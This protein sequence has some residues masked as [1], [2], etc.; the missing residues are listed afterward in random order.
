MYTL[1]TLLFL[2]CA[3]LLIAGLIKPSFFAGLLKHNISRKQIGIVLGTATFISIILVGVAAPAKQQN[4]S[5]VAGGS[6][7]TQQLPQPSKDT[8]PPSVT[9]VQPSATIKTTT[10]SVSAS[11]SESGS[12]IDSASANIYLDNAAIATCTRSATIINCTTQGLSEGAH[13]ITASVKDVAGNIGKG[14][15]TFTVDSVA[16][17]VSAITP[18]GDITVNSTTVVVTYSE[19]GSGINTKAVVVNLDGAPI[20]GCTVGP[21]TASCPSNGIANGSHTISVSANDLAGNTGTGSGT[22]SISPPAP[23]DSSGGGGYTNVD[24][25]HVASPGS[26]PN[27]ATAQCADGTY[28]Y[29]QHRRGTCSSHGGVSQWLRNDIPN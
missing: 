7:E 10:T 4:V 2:A 18:S 22:F 16:P 11:F 24:G 8:T 9:N 19:S 3:G 12:G 17:V 21:T 14:T 15:G 6:V 29:S 25:N 5:N 13:N 27:G 26:D 20:A 1:V 28:S 23:P